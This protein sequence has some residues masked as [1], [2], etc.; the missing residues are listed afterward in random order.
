[1]T[2]G[3]LHPSSYGDAFADVYDSWYPTLGDESA[4]LAT[5]IQLARGHRALEL[6]VG[7]GR[8]AIPLVDAGIDVVGIDASEAMLAILRDKASSRPG[9][10]LICADMAD[11][12]VRGPFQ[13][14]YVA[15]NTLFNL[16]DEA[17]QQRCLRGIAELLAP[18][19]T[20]VIEAFTP[21]DGSA[22]A[23]LAIEVRSR[24]ADRLILI[25]SHHDPGSRVISGHHIEITST[26]TTVR[27]WRVSYLEPHDI[28][29]LAGL[30]G[31]S[32]VERHSDWSGGTFGE[33]SAAHVSYYRPSD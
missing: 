3:R 16:V 9:P 27:P 5:L 6:G 30:A 18:G 22:P 12:G 21:P 23:G 4:C 26:G 24:T 2:R 29:R 8:L 17:S 14:V 1:M 13:L 32:L 19:G 7:T 31:L 33:A 25:A 28:D 20:L 11:V 10:T 15:Y